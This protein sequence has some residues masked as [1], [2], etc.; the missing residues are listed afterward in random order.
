MS[1]YS[2]TRPFTLLLTVGYYIR[3]IRI[4]VGLQKNKTSEHKWVLKNNKGGLFI[5][6][7]WVWLVILISCMCG[8]MAANL[9]TTFVFQSD[10][11]SLLG[12]SQ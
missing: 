6:I 11:Y 1:V 9:K 10:T 8:D 12:I 3:Y 5:C 2:Y 4:I 7:K